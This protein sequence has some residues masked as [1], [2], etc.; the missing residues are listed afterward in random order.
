MS[1]QI[2]KHHGTYNRSKRSGGKSAIKYLVIHYTGG[3]GSAKNNC[4]YFSGGDRNASADYFIDD[5]GIWEYNDPDSGYHTWA[6]GDGGGKYGITNSNSIHIEVVNNGGPFSSKEI[7]YLTSLTQH[8]MSKYNIPADKVVRHYDASRKQCPHYYVV[9]PHT[10]DI[11]HKMITTVNKNEWKRDS[12]GWWYQYA[13]GTWPRDEWLKLEGEWYFF[14]KSG[15]A[16]TGW[17]KINNQWYY[18]DSNCKMKTGWIKLD[19]WYYLRTQD[20][21]SGP[22][23]SCVM[24]TTKPIDGKTYEFDKEGRC[25]N[26]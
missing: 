3:T 23:G 21:K 5:N 1:L 26:P 11:L 24:N 15:Y 25:L 13:D 10:W 6:V 4:I 16:V 17:Q 18:F 9:T 22:L 20:E 19:A 8:L 14:D 7:G 2:N 12:E